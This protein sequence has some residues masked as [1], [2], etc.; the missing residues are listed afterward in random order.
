MQEVTSLS[1]GVDTRSTPV[2]LLWCVGF[3]T[4]SPQFGPQSCSRTKRRTERRSTWPSMARSAGSCGTSRFARRRC[5]MSL[6]ASALIVAFPALCSFIMTINSA[7]CRPSLPMWGSMSKSAFISKASAAS[8][9]GASS[10]APNV[11]GVTVARACG[12][13]MG[14]FAT[15]HSAAAKG[16]FSAGGP[17]EGKKGRKLTACSGRTCCTEGARRGSTGCP[18]VKAPLAGGTYWGAAAD[19]A[20][21]RGPPT[22]TRTAPAGGFGQLQGQ[23]WAMKRPE[24][25]TCVDLCGL[26]ADGAPLITTGEAI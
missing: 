5:S 9:H 10:S 2:A 7:R 23:L 13:C 20:D 17:R 16:A 19:G 21:T 18:G 24:I 26:P 3:K 8:S 6:S 1:S 15:T 25:G 12:A 22:E 4:T 14:A 11:G